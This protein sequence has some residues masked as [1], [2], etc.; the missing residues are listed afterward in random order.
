[1]T[2]FWIALLGVLLLVSAGGLTYMRSRPI[3]EDTGQPQRSTRAL[4]RQRRA[5]MTTL[6]D[7]AN[8]PQTAYALRTAV[9]LAP[10]S[11]QALMIDM[12]DRGLV[13]TYTPEYDDTHNFPLPHYRLTD[14]GV[15]EAQLSGGDHASG[16]HRA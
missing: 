4:V 7:D 15:A 11:F 9:R 3:D 12:R 13:E 2:W 8:V 6:M 10:E 1:V 14:R 16:R 5:V